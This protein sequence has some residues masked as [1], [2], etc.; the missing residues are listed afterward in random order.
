MTSEG[1]IV[2]F[3]QIGGSIKVTAFDPI[4][5]TEVCIVGSPSASKQQLSELAVRKLLY[6]MNKEHK[7][8]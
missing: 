4:T 3:H 5:F 6:V 2:E 8:T 1:Y 7:E